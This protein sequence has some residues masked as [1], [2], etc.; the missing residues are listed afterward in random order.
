MSKIVPSFLKQQHNPSVDED[1]R[2]IA[3]L[4][5]AKNGIYFNVPGVDPWD[6]SRDARSYE[7]PYPVVAHPPCA[8]YSTYAT[9]G[10]SHAGT[11]VA[12]DD[13]GAFDAALHAVR[14]YGGVLEHPAGSKAWKLHG[15]ATPKRTGGW[16]PAGDGIGWTCYVEQGHYGHR[17]RKGTWLYAAHVALPDLQWGPSQAKIL[18]RPGYDLA[19]ERRRGA[20]E[21]MSH[22]ERLATPVGF[23]D[24]LI[25]MA[26]TASVPHENENP[27]RGM[28]PTNMFILYKTFSCRMHGLRRYAA[29]I[30]EDPDL[31]H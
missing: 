1:L 8:R 2:M 22:R 17:A 31:P 20:V 7:G 11:R 19:K 27:A 25:A 10:P 18:P 16:I 5:V 23:R 13:G 3:A 28:T 12:A 30:K 24:M 4:F 6:E 14:T 29:Q 21:R 9:G 26:R 15:F